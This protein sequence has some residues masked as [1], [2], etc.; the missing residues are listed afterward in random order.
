MSIFCSLLRCMLVSVPGQV[1]TAARRL[2]E[3]LAISPR[4]EVIVPYSFV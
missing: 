3:G 4:N 1:E 2:E